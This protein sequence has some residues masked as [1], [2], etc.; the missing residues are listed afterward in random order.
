MVALLAGAL[1]VVASGDDVASDDTADDPNGL[2]QGTWLDPS[3]PRPDFVLTDTDGQA[4]DFAAETSGRL[5]LLFFGFVSCPDVC[6]VHLA[7]LS[8]ALDQV[9]VDPLVVFVSVDPAR[10]APADIRTFLDGF[11]HDYVGLTGTPTDLAQAQE[12]AGIGVATI[13][14]EGDDTIVTHST[15][16]IAY[17]PDD[18]AHVT[19][20]FGTRSAAWVADLPLLADGTVEAAA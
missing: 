12:A 16:I 11:D 4:F 18:R 10:D 20:P 6:P 19:Y 13:E 15:E 1:V 8:A 7:T 9:S 3:R 2:V 14:G 5:T 17:T